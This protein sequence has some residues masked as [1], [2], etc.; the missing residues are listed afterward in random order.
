LLAK[1][2]FPCQAGRKVGGDS[3]PELKFLMSLHTKL[4]FQPR[5]EE[6]GK[7]KEKKEK[8]REFVDAVEIVLNL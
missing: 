6:R 3:V 4:P 1:Q 7:R 5:K 8:E 2:V